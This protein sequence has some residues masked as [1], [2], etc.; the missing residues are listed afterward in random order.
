MKHASN[1][2]AK[3][4]RCVKAV[5]KR[6]GAANAY[7][8]CTAA[9][10]RNK[11]KKGKRNPAD[12]A[13]QAF[14]EFHGRPSE[15]VVTVTRKIH[16]HGHLAAIGDLKA[17][18]GVTREGQR[19]VLQHFEDAKGKPAILC[20]NEK[21]TQLFIEGGNQNV[22]L[23]VFGLAADHELQ[24]LMEVR[25]I[26]YFTTKNHL[27]RDG[28][29]ATYVHKFDQPYPDLIFDVPNKQLLFA[30]GGYS[31]PPEGIDH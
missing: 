29:T 21:H 6:G 24:T 1:N 19:V 2:P 3:F 16:Y 14:E 18:K 5:K 20:E 11:G 7:A 22:D 31:M 9:G 4:D 23:S 12:A 8:V 15:E 28:G 17:L 13:A 25:V 10:T 30:G 27:G 26:E